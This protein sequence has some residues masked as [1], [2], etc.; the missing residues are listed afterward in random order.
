MFTGLNIGPS[1]NNFTVEQKKLDKDFYSCSF[2]T[3]LGEYE[4]NISLKN[5]KLV[6]NCESELDFLSIYSY[7]KEI[8]LEE[9]KSLS[10]NFKSCENNEQIFTAFINIFNGIT[11]TINDKKYESELNIKL[12]EDDSLIMNVK[13]P[14]IYGTYEKLE[15][16]FEKKP[17]VIIDQY[18]TLR[19]KYLKVKDLILYHSCSGRNNFFVPPAQEN[20]EEKLK[21]I[22]EDK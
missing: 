5:D 6:L 18:K 14:L 15:I 8:T 16:I 21:N 17:K 19:T 10:N 20:L 7:S 1:K 9:L 22:E 13:I 11:M 12:S 2:K 3:D 4:L